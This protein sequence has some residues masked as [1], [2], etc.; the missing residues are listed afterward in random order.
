M[1]AASRVVRPL[2]PLLLLIMLQT[3]AAILGGS[4]EASVSFPGIPW[5]GADGP[6]YR[7]DVDVPDW[8]EG[9]EVTVTFETNATVGIG[10]QGCWNVR[11]AEFTSPRPHV[12]ELTFQLGGPSAVTSNH[13]NRLGCLM[14]GTPDYAATSVRY[15]G[16]SCFV[17]PPPPPHLL[18]P[19]SADSSLGMRF[20]ITSRTQTGWNAEVK[21]DR[22]Q[23]GRVIRMDCHGAGFRIAEG[24]E[25]HASVL[26]A[27]P[28]W[29]EFMLGPG[30]TPLMAHD[31]QGDFPIIGSG[32]FTF[33]ADPA[34]LTAQS[35][36]PEAPTL[37][38]DSGMERP[39][40][41]PPAVAQPPSPLLPPP[42]HPS[43]APPSPL[44]RPPPSPP[45]PRPQPPPPPSPPDLFLAMFPGA[46]NPGGELAMLLL[47][48]ADAS[49]E[50]LRWALEERDRVD[51]EEATSKEHEVSLAL[52]LK[53]EV[54]GLVRGMSS[55]TVVE[56]F[57]ARNAALLRE[58]EVD[59][60]CCPTVAQVL[61]SQPVEEA[62]DASEEPGQAKGS[63]TAAPA[64]SHRSKQL[65]K[66]WAAAGLS[67]LAVLVCVCWC[68]R[69]FLRRVCCCCG[70]GDG[71]GEKD[72][73]AS[74]PRRQQRGR[75]AY[76]RGLEDADDE[77]EEDAEI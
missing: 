41:P 1:R 48:T 54:H 56:A 34:P 36:G 30:P 62:P 16:S 46:Y 5:V 66:A 32:S 38:C 23:T 61:E 43:P 35:A 50:R 39:T 47:A 15:V 63:G 77:E 59:L 74:R 3:S 53:R 8:L 45:P 71:E 76:E 22:W 29:V 68:M 44:P 57:A 33:R 24:T 25:A 64:I 51:G 72:E 73:T 49:N 21:L 27:T 26:R 65:V 28:T 14:K 9:A 13:P 2:A 42:P 69:C 37:L 60:A 67:T 55:R 7:M 4:C 19:C 40:P 18:Q 17:P 10:D 75:R 12:G 20:E 6:V 70:G 52:E 31:M 11:G 58:L